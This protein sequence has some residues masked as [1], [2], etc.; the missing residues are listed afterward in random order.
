MIRNF[1]LAALIAV[2]S[3]LSLV[4]CGNQSASNVDLPWRYEIFAF[5]DGHIKQYNV[6]DYDVISDTSIRI[7]WTDGK[8]F[9]ITADKFEV[10]KHLDSSK[11]E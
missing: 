8:S 5:R 7:V 6:Y 1:V 10:V 4:A 11:N 3:T 2:V 9:T